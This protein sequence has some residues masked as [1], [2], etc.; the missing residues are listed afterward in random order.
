ML[1]ATAVLMVGSIWRK[2][3][4]HQAEQ[5]A[6]TP[7]GEEA[8]PIPQGEEAQLNPQ[9]EEAQPIDPA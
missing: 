5:L 1:G 8:Q 2:S 4:L 3:K 9:V 7:R 6:L